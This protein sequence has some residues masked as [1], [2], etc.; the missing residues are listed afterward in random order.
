MKEVGSRTEG[1]EVLTVTEADDG[2][3]SDMIESVREQMI[4]H[5]KR[6][7]LVVLWSSIPCTGRSLVRTI[8]VIFESCT[9]FRRSYGK[10]SYGCRK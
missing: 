8:W 4:S 5:R 6:G 7:K 2:T 1:V 9:R 10:V 3:R